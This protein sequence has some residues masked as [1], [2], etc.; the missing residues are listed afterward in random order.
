MQYQ[1]EP[2]DKQQRTHSIIIH[3]NLLKNS[4]NLLLEITNNLTVII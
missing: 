4:K 2:S 3:K 1:Q